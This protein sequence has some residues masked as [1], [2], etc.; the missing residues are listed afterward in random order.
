MKNKIRNLTILALASLCSPLFGQ[1]TATPAINVDEVT[2]LFEGNQNVSKEAVLA[3]IR[4]KKGSPFDQISLDNSIRSLYATG[5]YEFIEAQK[6]VDGNGNLDIELVVSPRMK[7]GQIVFKGNKRYEASKL[8]KEILSYSGSILD[9]VRVKTDADKLKTFYDKKGY[10]LSKIDY[11]IQRNAESGVGAVIFSIDEGESIKIQN[12]RFEGSPYIEAEPAGF[13]GSIFEESPPKGVVTSKQLVKLMRTDTWIPLI[14][15]L[16]DN[17]RLEENAL[18]MDLENLRTFYKNKGYLDVEID[19][20]K[21]RFEFPNDEEAG[22]MDLIIP[23]TEGRVYKVGKITMSG[24][25]LFDTDLLMRLLD[26]GEGDT[27]SPM[28][29]DSSATSIKDYYGQ[30][31]YL[32]SFARMKRK[33]N[34]E[35]G[36]IDLDIEI[37]ESDRFYIESINIQGNTKTKSEVIIRELAFAPGEIFDLV[38]MKQS[39]ARLNSTRFFEEVKLTPEATNIPNRRNLKVVVKE[40]RTGNLTFGAGFSTVE[41]L[42]AT[43]ELSQSNFDWK[44]YDNWFQGAGQ[45]FRISVS[46][47]LESNQ[48][49]LSFEEPW[50]FNRQIAFGTDLYRTD[51]GYYS[52]YYSEL[53]TGATFYLRKRL[54]E[55]VEGRLSYTFENID[56]YDV[57]DDAPDFISNEEGGRTVSEIGLSFLRDSRDNYMMPTSGTRFEL[58]QNFAGGPLMADTNFYR[59][60]GRAGAWFPTFDAGKQVFSIVGRAGSITGFG[61]QDVPYFEKF[62]LGGGYNMRGFEYRKVGKLDEDTEEPYGGNT[63]AFLSLEYSIELFEPVRFAVF[64]DIGF[65]NEDSWDFDP[66]G[67]N[68]DFGFG[69]RILMMGAPMRI[70]IGFPLTTG[71]YNN[72]GMQFNFS[73]GTIF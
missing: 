6:T 15:Y 68:S 46:V 41:S 48:V 69:L 31:G 3:H 54:F 73:F 25:T 26:L 10:A 51:T 24:N 45:K 70:D 43:V 42:V 13:F 52:D 66:S 40:G 8:Q 53:R 55:L 59:I 44:N 28:L 72:D 2:V 11:D 12:I 16:T 5:L 39:E 18:E 63:F 60:E 29:V 4:L 50:I 49:I 7:I 33:P 17:G 47:G 23:I 38:R 22:D 32:D 35:T 71:E 9:E 30:W 20:S 27:F 67:Y 62:F 58:L 37:T 34:L 1:N 14:S 19:E 64:Y 65:V 61:G 36:D 56:I 21:V 57:E